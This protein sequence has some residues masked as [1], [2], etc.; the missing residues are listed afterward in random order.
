[1]ALDKVEY[2]LDG[3]TYVL[4][5]DSETGKYKYAGIAP[6]KSSYNQ[7]DHK[8]SSVLKA[9]DKAGN[10]TAIDKNNATFGSEMLIDVNEKIPPVITPVLPGAGAYLTSHSVSIQFD[11][12]DN[13]SGVNPDSISLQ[14]DGGEAITTGL[15]KS[16]IS[17]GY[18]CTYTATIVDGNHTISINAEDNDGN[19][20]IQKTVAFTVDTVPPELNV[21]TPADNQIT[22]KQVGTVS[23]T[24]NDA[25]SAP[26]TIQ[27]KLNDVDQGTVPVAANGTFSKSVT[28]KNGANVIYVKA[29]DKAGKYSELT[30]NVIYDPDAPVV[31][32]VKF[33]P[34]PVAAGQ[35]FTIEAEITDD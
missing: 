33:T 22:N 24:T 10:V 6:T 29:T 27:I 23:G 13:D 26:V 19:A 35:P 30:I 15:T 21:P 20:A 8:Y 31:H 32:S 16:Q 2:S 12:T 18:Q 28:Y 3:Q 14:I 1:M 4:T 25:T 7:P 17:G 9:T 11:V 5:K 34:N